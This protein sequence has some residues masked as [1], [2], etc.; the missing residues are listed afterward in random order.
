MIFKLKLYK[1]F[2]LKF[3]N[4]IFKREN[5]INVELLRRIILLKEMT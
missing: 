5:Y 4:F 1:I 3:F 2:I